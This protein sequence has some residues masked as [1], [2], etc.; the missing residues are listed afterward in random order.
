MT[1]NLKINSMIDT[2]C[3]MVENVE[4]GTESPFE[5]IAYLKELNTIILESQKQIMDVVIHESRYEDKTFSKGDHVF[6]KVSGRAIYNFKKLSDW[7][8]AKDNLTQIET[9][10]KTAFRNYSNGLTNVTDDGEVLQMPEVKHTNDT[11]SIKL[12]ANKII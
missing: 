8:Q 7:K 6:T 11:I 4:E 3:K 9:K 2:I 10:Y 12:N 5:A 1:N